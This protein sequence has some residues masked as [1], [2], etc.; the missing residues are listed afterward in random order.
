M[1]AGVVG[2]A[3]A[4]TDCGSVTAVPLYGA[5]PLVDSGADSPSAGDASEASAPPIDA[6]ADVNG[7]DTGT[8]TGSQ[9]ATED[10]GGG[11][12]LYGAP[13]PPPEAGGP[14]QDG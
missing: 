1:A 12:A 9:D 14:G 3:I 4:G 2:A 11:I 8:D 5:P 7:A 6:T 13:P 10:F